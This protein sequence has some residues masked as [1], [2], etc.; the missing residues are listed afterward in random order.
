M[1]EIKGWAVEQFG[2]VALGDK[3]RTQRAVDMAQAMARRPGDGL[4][5]QMGDWNGQGGAYRLLDNEAVSHEGLRRPHW[6]AT[7][8]RAGQSG[9]VVLM[10]Q[11]I[12]ELD[13]SV[14]AA[15]GGLGPIGDIADGVCWC[16]I[17]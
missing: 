10:V 3:R 8:Q 13:H 6:A 16:I 11:D 9:R 1:D 7:R 5:K 17:P 4:V 14:H 12:T 15:T 2:R